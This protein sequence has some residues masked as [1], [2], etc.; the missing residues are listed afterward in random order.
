MNAVVVDTHAII[1]YLLSSP[2][3]SDNALQ[4]IDLAEV[5]IVIG[6]CFLLI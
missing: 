5:L 1:W 4:A 2:R 3:L 6:K